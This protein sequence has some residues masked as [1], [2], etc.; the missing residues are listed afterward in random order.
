MVIPRRVRAVVIV[1]LIMISVLVPFAL[2]PGKASALTDHAPIVING[3]GG[4]TNASG[5]VWGSGTPVDPYIIEGWN[6]TGM[7]DGGIWISN[8]DS[9]FVVRNISIS[10]VPMWS[11]G[12]QLQGVSNGLIRDA[13]IDVG[14]YGMRLYQTKN[15]SLVNVSTTNCDMAAYHIRNAKNLSIIANYIDNCSETIDA[16]DANDTI[17][18]DTV[19]PSAFHAITFLASYN[20]SIIG[21]HIS[22]CGYPITI[23]G[24]DWIISNNSI[25]DSEGSI[26]VGADRVMIYGNNV[27]RTVW[28]ISVSKGTDCQIIGNWIGDMTW[29]GIQVGS[30]TPVSNVIV[31]SNLLKDI[32]GIGIQSY[33]CS[34][35]QV[36]SN[37]IDNASMRCIELESCKQT[38]ISNN[39]VSNSSSGIE[40]KASDFV[41]IRDNEIYNCSQGIYATGVVNLTIRHNHIS[42]CTYAGASVGQCDNLTISNNSI[43]SGSYYGMTIGL[44]N[45]TTISGNRII[46]NGDDGIRIDDGNRTIC[47]ENLIAENENRGIETVLTGNCTI[48]QNVLYRNSWGAFIWMSDNVTIYHNCFSSNHASDMDSENISWDDGYPSGGNYW[49]DYA[50]VD[51]FSGPSQ[52]IPGKDGIGD[53]PYQVDSD[54]SDRYPI[55][56][57]SALDDSPP[58][59]VIDISGTMGANGWYASYVK[60]WLNSTDTGIGVAAA[61]FRL[62]PLEPFREYDGAV[63]MLGPCNLTIEYYATDFLGNQETVKNQHLGIDMT[64]P[65]MGTKIFGVDGENGWHISEVMIQISPYDGASGVK[66]TRYSVDDGSW[67]N[68]TS[69]NISSDGEHT[70]EYQS[71]DNAKHTSDVQAFDVRI[72]TTR[73]ILA[74][75][76]ANGTA[77]QVGKVNISWVGSDATSGIDHYVYWIFGPGGYYHEDITDTTSLNLSDLPAGD[78]NISIRAVD[79]A[80][81]VRDCTVNFEIS[82]GGGVFAGDLLGIAFVI[83]TLALLAGIAIPK[84]FAMRRKAKESDSRAAIKDIT[85]AQVIMKEAEPPTG[86]ELPAQ[87]GH[88]P[89]DS[90]PKIEK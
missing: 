11:T 73:P 25:S 15:C 8:T 70:V 37:S 82:T 34:G 14:Y 21:N 64:P 5:V 9:S 10:G 45:D 31:A 74:L 12:I 35:L 7:W 51:D 71:E 43:E 27:T 39:T 66:W 30:G 36:L 29:G 90:P 59:T 20:C 84:M 17:I 26:S 67:V 24:A 69:F 16:Q 1:M 57:K 81:N 19:I 80:G 63:L 88:L 78:Y 76:P 87:Q 44:C 49:W 42:F 56:N 53:T 79:R 6:I 47:K 75:V 58:V 52:D 50:G 72:D 3:N 18:E 60:F 85:T 55:M 4:F 2:I 13:T 61:Y 86:A 32:P 41:L 89:S 33:G 54:S 83:L 46:G 62:S 40:I 38:S 22:S 23:D 28:P 77:F 68:G 48:V 65:Y